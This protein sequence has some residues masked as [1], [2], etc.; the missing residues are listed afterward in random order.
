MNMNNVQ[1]KH[2]YKKK[3]IFQALFVID[4]VMSAASDVLNLAEENSTR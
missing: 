1:H 2:E 3:K 4:P